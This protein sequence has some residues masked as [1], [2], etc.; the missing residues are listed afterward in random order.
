MSNFLKKLST[1]LVA[2]CLFAVLSRAAEKDDAFAL[3][4]NVLYDAALY[5]SIGVEWRFSSH[6]S[7]GMDCSVAWW[8]RK[9]DHLYYQIASAVPEIR[10]W[11]SENHSL[12][13]FAGAGLYD[14]GTSR[15]GYQGEFVMAGV[16]YSY[17]FSIGRNLSL[18]LGMGIGYLNTV[19]DE[20]IP[21]DNHY[22]YQ[23]AGKTQYVGPVKADVSLVWHIRNRKDGGKK[24]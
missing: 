6:W 5:P 3:R 1:M 2:L 17:M 22:V 14:F 21:L 19:Y 13:A 11:L 12:G 15:K 10:Y 23:K 16:G 9:T 18:N 7:A 20:Y 8:S 4:T 24:R